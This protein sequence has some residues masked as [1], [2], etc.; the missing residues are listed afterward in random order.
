[1]EQDLGG[2]RRILERLG[3]SSAERLSRAKTDRERAYLRSIETLYGAGDPS[4]RLGTD[5]DARD[6]AYLEEMRRIHAAYPDDVDAAAFYG[7]ALLGSAHNGRDTA[8]YEKAAAALEPAFA[9]HPDHP[10]LAHYL[11]HSY[12]DPEHAPLGLPAARRYFTIASSAP[13][14]LHMTS[15]IYLAA[16]MWDD[17]V[18]ANA[19]ATKVHLPVP[20]LVTNTGILDQSWPRPRRLPSKSLPICWSGR[21]RRPAK[22][23]RVRCGKACACSRPGMRSAS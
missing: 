2:A 13:H 21:K 12:D 16:G 4:K 1:M 22:G 7:R 5:K 15:H 23:S 18:A 14:A 19:Q 11:I 9:A 10:G 8:T 20:A 3:S 17:V 6:V